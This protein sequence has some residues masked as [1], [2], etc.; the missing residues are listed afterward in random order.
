[1]GDSSVKMLEGFRR[2][3]E[4]MEKVRQCGG[5]DIE[6]LMKAKPGLCNFVA[7]ETTKDKPAPRYIV[8]YARLGIHK[9]N[10]IQ[11]TNLELHGIEKYNVFH[12]VPYSIYFVTAVAKDPAAG[13]SLVTFQTSFYEE[14]FGVKSLSC[15]I[16]R[17]K[18]GP[19]EEDNA[20]N[21]WVQSDDEF[22]DKSELPEWPGENAFDDKKHY[23]VVKKSELRENDWIR[24]YLELAFLTAHLSIRSLDLSKVVITKVAVY[25]SD[26]DMALPNEKLNARNA[27]FYIKYKYCPNENEAHGC[28]PTRDGVAIGTNLELHG[29]EKYNVLRKIPY[30]IHFVTAVAKDPAAGGSLVTF[31]TSF[32]EEVYG[33]SLSCFIARPKPGPHEEDNAYNLWVQSDN[34][35]DDETEDKSEL[36]E[37]PGENAFDDKK[38]Y[39]VVEKSELGKNDWIRVYLELAFLVP[40]LSIRS[41]DLSKVVITKVA[42]YT[43]DEDMALPNEKLNA[44]NAIF[45]IKYK[46]CP[47]ENEDHGCK[48]TRDGVAIVRRKMDKISGYTTL[49]FQGDCNW[50]DTFL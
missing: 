10:M 24:V 43:S 50:R 4:F 28:K 26:E 36:P 12:K 46:Y 15:F 34:E 8:L 30:F 49:S 23:Y 16:A 35:S 7:S 18:P 6:H 37:W 32:Y 21:L 41:L 33:K 1:M 42:V 19:H 11:G 13:G 25:T 14:V 39:Y 44:R 45:Y 22:E 9:Y 48:P 3:R 31:Q 17:P 47:N 5:F 27:I 29:I 38:H 40:N 20:Y 2:E